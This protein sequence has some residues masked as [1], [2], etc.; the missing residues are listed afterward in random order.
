MRRV[1]WVALGAAAGVL[2]V[3]KLN[4]TAQAYTPEGMARSLAGVADGLREVADAVR[5][6]MALR[7]QELRVA[8]G[9]DTGDLDPEAARDLLERPTAPR[10]RG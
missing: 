6:G 1:F 2:V 7:E 8:L 3:R 4:K 9:V 10:H 5:E